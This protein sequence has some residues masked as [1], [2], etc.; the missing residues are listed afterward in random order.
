LGQ[1]K[2]GVS[3]WKS[4]SEPICLQLKPEITDDAAD[5]SKPSGSHLSAKNDSDGAA[6]NK[7]QEQQ[8]GDNDLNDAA[9]DL[10]DAAD[11]SKPSGSYLAA[12]NDSDDTAPYKKLKEDDDSDDAKND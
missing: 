9:D 3:P 5:D 11:D 6:H 8:Q 2:F 1:T 4:P 12:K 7:K 10:N